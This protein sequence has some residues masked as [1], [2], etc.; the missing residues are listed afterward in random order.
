MDGGRDGDHRLSDAIVV[1]AGLT[2]LACAYELQR[3]GHRVHVLESGPRIGGVVGTFETGGFLFERGPNTVPAGATHLR[4]VAGALGCADRMVTSRPEA[5]RRYLF[6]G[7]H[8]RPLPESPRALLSTPLLSWRAKRRILTEPFRRFDPA[9]F[10]GGEPTL[11]DF[12]TERIGA[13]ATR[14]F[15]G[16]FVRGVYAA[17]IDELGARSAFP[18]LWAMAEASGG[19]LRGMAR[20]G[21]AAR[22]ARRAGAE[23]PPG[24]RTSATDLIS[25]SGGF[26][27]LVR[28]FESALEG[29]I[30]RNTNVAEIERGPGGWRAVLDSGE[31]LAC[32]ELVLA[33]PAPSAAPLVAMCAPE[34]LDLTALERVEHAA[35]TAVHLGLEN[36][37]LPPGFGF[38]V[39]PDEE[40]RRDPRTPPV[41]G[42]LFISNLFAGRAPSGTSSVTAMFRGGD[43]AHLVGDELIGRAVLAVER[44]LEGYERAHAEAPRRAAPP[45]VVASRVQR[46]TNVIPRYAPGHAERF[47]ALQR[48]AARTLPG[49]HLAGNYVG[50]V[51]VDDRLGHGRAVAAH[52]ADRLAHVVERDASRGSGATP[53]LRAGGGEAS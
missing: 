16:A 13:E 36:A 40:A 49:L 26:S 25:F 38:L 23:L 28:A 9:R 4:E 15:A 8:L 39:P 29:R 10:G 41:L 20:R 24:P 17:E 14:T 30:S 12:L 5:K 35:I 31:A 3:R 44:G 46:W 51:S 21:R 27:V 22:R 34:R 53:L 42:A 37:P 18:R 47:D 50:G 43:V 11:E 48:S 6:Q 1:G 2:G 33:V 19:L 7:G 52:I 32:R 45:R